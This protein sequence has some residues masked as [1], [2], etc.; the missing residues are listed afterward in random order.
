MNSVKVEDLRLFLKIKSCNQ[1]KVILH[2][3][4]LLPPYI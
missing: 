1:V 4:T 3:P 2:L